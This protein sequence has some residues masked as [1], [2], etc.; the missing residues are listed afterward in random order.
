MLVLAALAPHLITLNKDL[1]EKPGS[2][3]QH[4]GTLSTKCLNAELRKSLPECVLRLVLIVTV[5]HLCNELVRSVRPSVMIIMS[6]TLQI[7]QLSGHYH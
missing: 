2:T 1:P 5:A 3:G 6:Q 4:K 7:E